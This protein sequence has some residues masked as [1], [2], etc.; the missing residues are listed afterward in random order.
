M[1]ASQ[2]QFAI[3]SLTF[4]VDAAGTVEATRVSTKV[5]TTAIKAVGDVIEAWVNNQS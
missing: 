1:M 4:P 5:I 2:K 3:Q